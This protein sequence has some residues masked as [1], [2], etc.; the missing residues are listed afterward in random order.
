MEC[1]IFDV[2]TVGTSWESLEPAIQASLLRSATSDDERQEVR[3]SLSLFPVTAQIACIALYSPE[4]DHAAVFFQAP[5]GGVSQLREEK[6][7]FVPCTEKELLTHFWEAAARAKQFVTF[8][9]RGFDC[10]F[11]LV[12]SAANRVRPTADLMPN[13]YSNQHVD[14]MDQF[15]Y[16]GA[17]RRRFSLEVWCS[18]LGVEQP[19]REVHGSEV[20][21]LYAA[22]EYMKIARYCLGDAQAT[23]QLFDLWSKYMRFPSAGQEQTPK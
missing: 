4:Q 11:L 15:T 14:L 6:A 10:P 7:V 9:G 18:A 17:F 5:A 3:D 16:F 21:A 20:G 8:N 2:E 22:G 13:R 19:K 12:R 1:L 23:A